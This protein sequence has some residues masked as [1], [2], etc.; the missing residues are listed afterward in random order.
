[1]QRGPSLSLRQNA[2]VEPKAFERAIDLLRALNEH[3]VEY[4]LVGSLALGFQGFARATEDVDL[5]LRPTR[6]NVERLKSALR[7]V[8]DDPCL[9]EILYEDLAGEYPTIR[10]GPPEDVF[11][12]DLLARLGV[13][14]S[15]EDLESEEKVI[16]G[17]PV[18]VATPKTLYRMKRNTVRGK[19]RVD[20][21][22]LRQTYPEVED[23]L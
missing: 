14:F 2:I 10:Y 19:D 12:V 8:W 7:S 20:A 4:I 23:A 13:T 9:D 18:Q 22:A 17:V 6:E 1:M 21:E 3:N 5:F 15:F 11:V 16:R